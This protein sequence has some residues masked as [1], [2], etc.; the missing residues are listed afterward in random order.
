MVLD[1]EKIVKE[2]CQKIYVGPSAKWL[3]GADKLPDWIRSYLENMKKNMHNFRITCCLNL[4][5][6]CVKFF[7][8]GPK[9]S[10]TLILSLF[11]SAREE[12]VGSKN[13]IK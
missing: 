9:I 11:M 1:I 13:M 4:R 3:N 7:E 2:E 12:L 5:K 10:S 8:F 6:L